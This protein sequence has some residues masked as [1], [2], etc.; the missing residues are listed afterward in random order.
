MPHE[1]L[2][3][4]GLLLAAVVAAFAISS[5]VGML[6]ASLWAPRYPLSGASDEPDP[7]WARPDSAHPPSAG[8][9]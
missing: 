3:H 1:L 6:I 5:V 9:P 4:S 2:Y 7:R 8:R